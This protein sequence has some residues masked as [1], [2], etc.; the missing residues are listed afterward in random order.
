MLEGLFGRK[1]GADPEEL[2]KQAQA[3][4]GSVADNGPGEDADVAA[5]MASITEE[6]NDPHAPAG[7]VMDTRIPEGGGP[8]VGVEVP[9]DSGTDLRAREISH[10]GGVLRSTDDDIRV[11]LPGKQDGAME[12]PKVAAAETV[13]PVAEADAGGSALTETAS[14]LDSLINTAEKAKGGKALE[15][16]MDTHYSGQQGRLPES[17]R[18]ELRGIQEK[19]LASGSKNPGAEAAREYDEKFKGLGDD[20]LRTKF[21]GAVVEDSGVAAPDGPIAAEID[22]VVGPIS[23]P[24]GA[25]EA[26]KRDAGGGR[27][28]PPKLKSPVRNVGSEKEEGEPKSADKKPATASA[29]ASGEGGDGNGETKTE[30]KLNKPVEKVKEGDVS[31]LKSRKVVYGRARE[32]MLNAQER[33]LENLQKKERSATEAP[34]EVIGSE[35]YKAF[36]DKGVVSDERLGAIADKVKNGEGLSPYETE[37]FTD[38]TADINEILRK[39]AAA[40]TPKVA[41][42]EKDPKKMTDAEYLVYLAGG[43]T[44]PEGGREEVSSPESVEEAKHE[45]SKAA[46]RE[47]RA[48]LD[49]HDLDEEAALQYIDKNADKFVSS[50]D[51]EN[52]KAFRGLVDVLGGDDRLANKIRAAILYDYIGQ[53]TQQAA[54]EALPVAPV[55]PVVPVV[56]ATA[57]PGAPP[58]EPPA[59]GGGE[60]DGEG[61]D[62]GGEGGPDL[63]EADE[64]SADDH[65]KALDDA[66]GEE[67]PPESIVNFLKRQGKTSMLKRVLGATAIVGLGIGVG[68]F[69]AAPLAA[70]AGIAGIAGTTGAGMFAGLLTGAT[71]GAVRSTFSADRASRLLKERQA[72]GLEEDTKLEHWGRHIGKQMAWGSLFGAI[73]G[74]VGGYFSE[75]IKAGL[76]SAG[77]WLSSQW[78]SFNGVEALGTKVDAMGTTLAD[79]TAALGGLDAKLGALDTRLDGVG[80]SL[81][82]VLQHVHENGR[83][84]D[85]VLRE[86]Y[87]Q[88][89]DISALGAYVSDL[90]ADVQVFIERHTTIIENYY[91]LERGIVA[92]ELAVPEVGSLAIAARTPWDATGELVG[93]FAGLD[94]KEALWLQDAIEDY[95][96]DGSSRG[97]DK[98]PQ[99]IA[100]LLEKM[101]G[102]EGAQAG[103]LPSGV[104][105]D[106]EVMFKDD[107][108]VSDLTRRI[109]EAD[110]LAGATKDKLHAIIEQLSTRASR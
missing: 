82:H 61:G 24:G 58:E 67:K 23:P 78:Q 110:G 18:E 106:F 86:L 44:P 36:R 85:E 33:D 74:G 39:K 49:G 34:A 4:I 10:L 6:K 1:K 25:T 89:E 43:G 19:A 11:T 55:A 37:I 57:A 93:G 66:A 101:T 59:G 22:G 13:P 107:G 64:A 108:I 84:L 75:E 17:Y 40:E 94:A 42:K 79:H 26:E 88:G 80:D 99:L 62:E 87:A 68:T 31:S 63:P 56:A 30:S 20:E 35:E 91:L 51:D 41:T 83:T 72:Q 46:R 102:I 96:Q 77:D 48:F 103:K 109:E 47:I 2:K 32:Q 50:N 52:E 70:Y 3:A 8:A 76:N 100:G 90:P 28:M 71:T 54:A 81:K 45:L 73:G 16:M 69:A 7:S 98:S 15:G 97:Y 38:R 5:A 92:P 12:A 104:K 29:G 14:D 9:P 65:L 27:T 95:V 60:G 105:F 53:L 21:I